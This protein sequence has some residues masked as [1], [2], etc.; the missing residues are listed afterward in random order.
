MTTYLVPIQ[1]ALIVFFV[2]INIIAVP[3][4]LWEY[5][6]KGALTLFKGIVIYSFIFYLITAFFMT[7]LPLPSKEFVATLT[8]A[9]AQ[10]TPFMFVQDIIRETSL[11]L[12]NLRSYFSALTQ[13]V[14]LQVVF[15]IILTIPFGVYL[16]YYFKK[17][18]KTVV[19]RTDL[20][21]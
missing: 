4:L 14:V 8:G 5:H 15:N 17:D 18:L 1:T 2:L 10:L 20:V 21:R 11:E 3:V 19:F 16:R 13:P 7:L 9:Y 12:L 6:K